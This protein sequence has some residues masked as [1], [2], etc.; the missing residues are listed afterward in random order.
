MIQIKKTFLRNI[1]D[2]CE[3]HFVSLEPFITAKLSKLSNRQ[4]I[5]ITTNLKRILI[6]KPEELDRVNKEY[7]AFCTAIGKGKIKN[8]NRGLNS[9]FDYKQFTKKDT[10]YYCGY[11]L[12]K[13]LK[14][15]TCP[16]CNRNYTVTVAEGRKRTVRPDFDHFFP[17]KQYPL[18][19]LSFYNLIP[20]CLICNRTIKNQAKIIN[21]KYIHPYEEGFENALKINYFPMDT[22][23]SVGLNS[24]FKIN[25]ILNPLEPNKAKKCKESFK[26]FKLKEIYKESHS[27]EIADLIRKHYVSNGKYLESLKQAFP[28]IGNI[29]ELYRLAF[30]NYYSEDD[31]EKRPLSKLTKDVVEQLIFIIPS[32]SKK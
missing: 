12:A 4:S 28:A 10:S 9:V 26:L 24:N 30:G 32:E 8:T 21:G 16:Y 2:I 23:S 11:D 29:D 1:D 25:T 19:A 5:F 6:S 31:F 15:N 13:K 27:G 22:D 14:V 18:L 17:R 20:S 7:F 3:Q